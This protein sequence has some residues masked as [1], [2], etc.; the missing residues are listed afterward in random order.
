MAIFTSITDETLHCGIFSSLCTLSFRVFELQYV[1]VVQT[2]T[3]FQGSGW[4]WDWCKRSVHPSFEKNLNIFSLV[5]TN[6]E[7]HRHF[8]TETT[9]PEEI[10]RSV[11]Y[12]FAIALITTPVKFHSPPLYWGGG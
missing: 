12:P 7:P 2:Q 8:E 5:P 6:P 3:W 9:F 1:Y 11:N 4:V 10:A